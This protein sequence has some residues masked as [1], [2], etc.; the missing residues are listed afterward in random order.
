M[1]IIDR[2][3]MVRAEEMAFSQGI[4]Y[5]RLMENAGTAAARFIRE[6]VDTKNKNVVVVCGVGNNGGDGFVIAR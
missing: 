6:T 5:L 3:T 2:E 1:K 4:S